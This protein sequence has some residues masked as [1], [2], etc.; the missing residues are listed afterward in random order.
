MELLLLSRLFGIA[1]QM[2]FK[3][4]MKRDYERNERFERS[5]CNWE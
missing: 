3:K 4:K 1:F 5:S 2:A